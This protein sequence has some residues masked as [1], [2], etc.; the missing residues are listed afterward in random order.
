MTDGNYIM[1]PV[2]PIKSLMSL[3]HRTGAVVVVIVWQLDL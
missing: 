1:F 2:T 3:L